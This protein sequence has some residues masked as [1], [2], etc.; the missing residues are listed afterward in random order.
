MRNTAPER[1]PCME[2]RVS[3]S[4]QIPVPASVLFGILA[5][6]ANHLLIDGSGMLRRALSGETITQPG[7]AFVMAMHNDEMG[8]YEMTNY[9]TEFE[10]DRLITWEPVMSAASR[11]EDRPG[12]GHR[13]E[14]H[15]WC[16]EL[17][18][19][20]DGSTV[21]TEIYDCSRAPEWLR[22]ATQGGERWVP[23]MAETLAKLEALATADS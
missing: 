14:P 13:G 12:I 1:L 16:Y 20:T 3:V 18:P 22:Q 21:V 23:A 17:A 2:N 9:V 15:M 11:E 7:D 6:P 19:D 4:R 5:H 10:P 8:E